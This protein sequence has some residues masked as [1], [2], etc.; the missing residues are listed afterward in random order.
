MALLVPLP[1]PHSIAL[2]IVGSCLPVLPPVVGVLALPVSLA[3]SL[4]GSVIGIAGQFG[5]LPLG[6]SGPLT[7]FIG[8]EA[9][10]FDAGMG[11][12]MGAAVG[13]SP[14]MVHG[15]ALPRRGPGCSGPA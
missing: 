4:V 10:G 12:K 14:S 8:A 2:A 13:A 15:T 9:L 1:L 11:H 3:V 5:S 7:G 6:F